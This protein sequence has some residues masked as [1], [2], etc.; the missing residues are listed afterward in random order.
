[1]TL[2]VAL[3]NIGAR[4]NVKIYITDG[5]INTA[6]TTG[7][8]TEAVPLNAGVWIIGQAVSGTTFDALLRHHPAERTGCTDPGHQADA[9]P[10]SA[11]RP[12]IEDTVTLNTDSAVRRD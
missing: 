12:V 7:T 4:P 11:S 10:G 6:V 3:T 8:Y 2:S 5:F 1:M 9:L